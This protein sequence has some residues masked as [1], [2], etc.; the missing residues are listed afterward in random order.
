MK[1]AG[2]VPVTVSVHR[3]AGAVEIEV[4]N[5]APSEGAPDTPFSPIES[6]GRGLIGIEERASIIGGTVEA[7]PRP[8]GGFRVWARLPIGGD[9]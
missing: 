3:T 7:G 6:G 4:L 9:A 1:H 8:S 5:D 2:V